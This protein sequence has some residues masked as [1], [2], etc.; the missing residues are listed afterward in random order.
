EYELE[1]KDQQE[2][3]DG[4]KKFVILFNNLKQFEEADII[5]NNKS[6]K[7]NISTNNKNI[8]YQIESIFHTF[9]NSIFKEI[10][11]NVRGICKLNIEDFIEIINNFDDQKDREKNFNNAKYNIISII[12]D[13][14]MKENI[15]YK[16]EKI[17]YNFT[18]YIYQEILLLNKDKNQLTI[19]FSKEKPRLNKKEKIILEI[20]Q[21]N[22]LNEK[23][24]DSEIIFESDQ[25]ERETSEYENIK[26]PKKLYKN[27]NIGLNQDDNETEEKKDRRLIYSNK[28]RDIKNQILIYQ[29]N[30]DK[31]KL[32][33]INNIVLSVNPFKSIVEMNF[34]FDRISDK[35]VKQIIKCSNNGHID[36][37]YPKLPCQ[38]SNRKNHVLCDC[39]YGDR[40]EKN[41]IFGKTDRFN[42]LNCG[43]VSKKLQEKFSEDYTSLCRVCEENYI[44]KD[45]EYK[46]LFEKNYIFG[47]YDINKKLGCRCLYNEIQEKYRELLL[48][49]PETSQKR[50]YHCCT[51]KK[52]FYYHQ[53]KDG[54]KYLSCYEVFCERLPENDY[55][56][57]TYLQ[58]DKYRRNLVRCV[59]YNKEYK[60]GNFLE[61]EGDFCDIH[62][63]VAYKNSQGTIDKWDEN[64]Y[65]ES[66]SS[67]KKDKGKSAEIPLD[68]IIEVKR[69]RKLIINNYTFDDNIDIIEMINKE[70][71]RFGSLK[72]ITI[73]KECFSFINRVKNNLCINCD[74][75]KVLE[76]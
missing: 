62:H 41:Y 35:D 38:V 55:R 29:I 28:D 47:R 18:Y 33:K 73:C 69:I 8:N 74:K 61:E 56:K 76:K 30:Q 20:N 64:D 12:K 13:L 36:I 24:E 22:E 27:E 26:V 71:K 60:R 14:S 51:C 19:K 43:C 7:L 37:H 3:K 49:K 53:L 1:K 25:E 32:R 50:K 21:E 44:L 15:D 65:E 2:I 39:R 58:S 9:T 40:F 42:R 17:L 63:Q 6:D 10:F 23:E 48:I 72:N 68:E 66:E 16:I 57:I 31:N 75:T 46:D 67:I 4:F 45:C 52:I 70:Y 11:K 59:I 34:S 54:Y 5:K